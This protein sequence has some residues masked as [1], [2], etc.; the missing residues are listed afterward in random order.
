MFDL[1]PEKER[2]YSRSTIRWGLIGSVFMI[3]VGAF[4][5]FRYHDKL[6]FA[7]ILLGAFQLLIWGFQGRKLPSNDTDQSSVK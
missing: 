2:S 5:A 1:L 4:G 7:F 3:A 6:G